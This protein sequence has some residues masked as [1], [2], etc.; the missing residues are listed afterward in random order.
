MVWIR[1][2]KG[3]CF[4]RFGGRTIQERSRKQ[5]RAKEGGDGH[6]ILSKPDP[7]EQKEH[8]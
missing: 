3:K 4:R 2:E 8:I 6:G 5:E 1:S 7:L